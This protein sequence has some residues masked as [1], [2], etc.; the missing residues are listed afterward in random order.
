MMCLCRSTGRDRKVDHIK[1]EIDRENVLPGWDYIVDVYIG[2]SGN[3]IMTHHVLLE[4]VLE[5]TTVFCRREA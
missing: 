1:F 5:P 3:R 2:Y 4:Q